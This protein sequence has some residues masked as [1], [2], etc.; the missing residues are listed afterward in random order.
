[1]IRSEFAANQALAT[2]APQA[3]WAKPSICRRLAKPSLL[4]RL[5]SLF[6]A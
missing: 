6:A 2:R 4:A 1:M 3:A 5:L